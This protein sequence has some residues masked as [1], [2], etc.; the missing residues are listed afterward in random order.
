V[1]L[2]SN[3]KL[4]SQWVILARWIESDHRKCL[5][6]SQGGLVLFSKS[7]SCLGYFS[8]YCNKIPMKRNI[9]ERGLI[10]AHGFQVNSNRLHFVQSQETEMKV[11]AQP[12]PIV[13]PFSQFETPSPGHGATHI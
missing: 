3:K 6:Q 5:I 2:H 4:L 12:L 9:R 11:G 10:V 8:C 13:F 7:C 1:S